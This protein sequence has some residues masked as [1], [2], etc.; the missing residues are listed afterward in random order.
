MSPF[1]KVS[2]LGVVKLGFEPE[3]ADTVLREND[4]EWVA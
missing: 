4:V 3:K 1:F 2:P